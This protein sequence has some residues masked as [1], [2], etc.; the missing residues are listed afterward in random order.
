MGPTAVSTGSD[1]AVAV[2]VLDEVWLDRRAPVPWTVHAELDLPWTVD[3][4]GLRAAARR[5]LAQHPLLSARLDRVTGTW[6][7]GGHEPEPTVL[8]DDVAASALPPW[9]SDA[10]SQGFTLESTT[11]ARFHLVPGDGRSR[12]LIVTD[13]AVVDGIA[14]QHLTSTL[15]KALAD[16]TA[17][18]EPVDETWRAAHALTHVPPPPERVDAVVTRL[19]ALARSMPVRLVP[20]TTRTDEGYGAAYRALPTETVQALTRLSPVAPANDVVVAAVALATIAHNRRRRSPTLPMTI[21]VPVNLR[22]HR[23]WDRGVGNTAVSWPVRIDTEDPAAVLD[24]VS[25]Q[26]RPLRAG[27]LSPDVRGLLTHLASRPAMPMWARHGIASMTTVVSSIPTLPWL[28]PPGLDASGDLAIWGGAPASP[29]M[30]MTFVAMISPT[31]VRLSA[32]YLRSHHRAE[33]AQQFLTSVEEMVEHLVALDHSAA[34]L[35]DSHG[36]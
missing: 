32:R 35:E 15:L 36:R 16:P 31:E 6:I 4:D 17:P 23:S 25:Q 34:P 2:N 24:A 10:L 12:V 26:R 5:V 9:R 3:E 14:I 8:V 11:A 30:S 13:H 1:A 29:A 27:L 7:V 19:R 18:P 21:G 33:D 22:P 28:W 20:S